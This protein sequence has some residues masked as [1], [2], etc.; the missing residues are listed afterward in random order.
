M[1]RPQIRR[2]SPSFVIAAAALLVAVGG[3]AV[4]AI[5]AIPQGGRF[6]A[7]YQTSN[8]VL[9]RIVVLAEPNENCPATYARVS[10]SESGGGGPAGPQGPPGPQG[11]AGPAGSFDTTT[12]RLTVFERRV[13][14]RSGGTAVAR[15]P[16]GG[17]AVGGGGAVASSHEL[18]TSAP[19]VQNRTPIGW[20]V[21][22]L[23]KRRFTIVPGGREST[24]RSTN[25]PIHS[26]RF[27]VGARL[28]P[29]EPRNAPTVVT[30]YAICLRL[31]VEIPGRP[32]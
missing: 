2:P 13:T 25:I 15:C 20:E 22:P 16:V 19:H 12:L 27:D 4:A 11:P 1:R 5:A 29:L 18:A 9:N 7:C 10:W 3:S 23:E 8:D 31:P 17:R 24:F 32:Q 6:T 14:V 28:L 21:V 30:V 26:H